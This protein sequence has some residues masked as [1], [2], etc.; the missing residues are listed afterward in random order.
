MR[1]FTG[2]ISHPSTICRNRTG[3]AQGCRL[4]RRAGP[5][6]GGQTTIS[7]QPGRRTK[8]YQNGLFTALYQGL[9]VARTVEGPFTR[10]P[11]TTFQLLLLSSGVLYNVP[12]TA[13]TSL[14]RAA[15]FIF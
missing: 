11:N 14:P 12:P 1:A 13:L 6:N 10:S 7:L 9:F 15:G 4:S 3:Y 5:A 8:G 2:S